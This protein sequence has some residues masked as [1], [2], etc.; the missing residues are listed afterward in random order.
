MWTKGQVTRKTRK[1][2]ISEGFLQP[3]SKNILAHVFRRIIAGLL[4]CLTYC[5]SA[6]AYLKQLFKKCP[7]IILNTCQTIPPTRR[8]QDICGK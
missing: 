1:N 6:K 2:T 4:V 5:F 7:E 3:Q 8:L